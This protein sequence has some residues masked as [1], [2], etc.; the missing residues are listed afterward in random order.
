MQTGRKRM[1]AHDA[2][3]FSNPA[4]WSCQTCEYLIY[5][6]ADYSVGIQGGW[7]CEHPDDDMGFI[8]DDGKRKTNC[9]HWQE[10]AL[11]PST[12]V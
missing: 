12:H 11:P 8:G 6:Q 10:K 5:E 9:E 4:T 3:G 2:R 7:V 1:E